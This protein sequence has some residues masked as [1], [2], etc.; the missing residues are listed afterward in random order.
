[1]SGD[2]RYYFLERKTDALDIKT[3]LR[4]GTDILKAVNNQSAVTDSRVILSYVLNCG[5][6]FLYSHSDYMLTECEM[7]KFKE[8]IQLRS[9]GTPL[10]HI[11]GCQEFMSLDFTVNSNVLIPRQETE[12]L[13]ETLINYANNLKTT[14]KIKHIKILDIGTGSGCIAISLAFYIKNCYIEAVDISGDAIN[15]A[16]HNAAL[17]GVDNRITFILS[18]L[19]EDI[20]NNKFDI[21]VSNPPYIEKKQI[22]NLQTEVKDY[23]PILALDGGADGLDFYRKIIGK[24]VYYL[25]NNGLLAFEIGYN[26]AKDVTCLME[27]NFSKI[28]V[29]KDLDK[30]D[31]VVMGR[32]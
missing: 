11:T 12:I 22:D 17:N 14:D 8:L 5:N 24:A 7:K 16:K 4:K 1:M 27:Q 28:E 15:L 13:V 29:I 26:Q 31:R 23:E 19:F 18:D 20:G 21:I 2:V 3:I 32:N 6:V 9:E 30:N 25:N 10:Q